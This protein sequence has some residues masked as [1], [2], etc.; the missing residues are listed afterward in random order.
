M[1]I[2]WIEVLKKVYG[3]TIYT[4][5]VQSV[6]SKHHHL[7]MINV[8]V[9]RFRK[10]LYP[11]I[12]YRLCRISGEKDFWIRNFDSIITMP[13]D[14]TRGKNIALIFHID[15]S[16][17]PPYLKPSLIG[18]EKIFYH[19]LKKADAII[20]ISKYWQRHFEERGYPKVFLIYNGFDM[21]QFGF[22]EEEVLEFKRRFRL[23]GK[24][25]LYLGNCQHIK[26]V[27]EV[28]DRLKDLNVHLV[29]SGRKEVNIPALNLD[30]DYRD[31]LLLLRSSSLVITMS[32]FKEGWNRTAHEAMLCKTPVVGSG[33]GGMRELLEGGRQIICDGFDELREKASYALD[34]PE[35]GEM[36]FDFARQFTIKKFNEE[37]LRLIERLNP[38]RKDGTL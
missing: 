6:L 36:G 17:Q 21:D 38:V 22:G 20:T 30:L 27:V 28:Y 24:P 37:W 31:Y 10:Y 3:E 11:K 26:G 5:M 7:E 14:G 33:L 15:Y 25:I 4:S 13:Y 16:F 19:H 34:H 18:L 23:E 12:L 35:L 8:G 29:T 1:E 2:G 9:D 32:K